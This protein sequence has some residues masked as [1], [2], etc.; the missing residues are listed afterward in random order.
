M[1]L[2]VYIVASSYLTWPHRASLAI[3][4]ISII[5]MLLQMFKATF[6]K[7]SHKVLK[8]ENSRP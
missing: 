4:A 1:T 6:A 5:F 3:K 2:L 8:R 7:M